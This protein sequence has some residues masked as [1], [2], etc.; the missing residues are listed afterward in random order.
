MKTINYNL[1]LS[2]T[3]LN[4]LGS[5]KISSIKNQI[6]SDVGRIDLEGK[7]GTANAKLFFTPSEQRERLA[8]EFIF[9]TIN[10]DLSITEKLLFGTN[11]VYCNDQT[12]DEILNMSKISDIDIEQIVMTIDTV[13][14]LNTQLFDL[15][16]RYKT[17]TKS[18]LSKTKESFDLRKNNQDV[19]SLN[20]EINSMKEQL[21]EIKKL[22][23]TLEE[24]LS[25]VQTKS[26]E[27]LNDIFENKL[28]LI[29]KCFNTK[30]MYWTFNK[31]VE[32]YV[33]K[34]LKNNKTK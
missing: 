19:N 10:K 16:N 23:K 7:Y 2:S 9:K 15:K 5:K 4:S 22:I 31:L 6:N 13:K 11:I 20:V 21:N 33:I 24:K 17:L 26:T 3:E 14:T 12:F 32:K 29:N 30:N 1:L 28:K 34:K 18:Y 8:K 27:F 25:S